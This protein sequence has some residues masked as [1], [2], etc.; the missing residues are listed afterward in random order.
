MNLQFDSKTRLSITD[1]LSHTLLEIIGK[2]NKRSIGLVIDSNIATHPDIKKMETALQAHHILLERIFQSSEPT[3][4]MVDS[5]AD[6][7]RSHTMDWIIGIGGGSTLD[8]AKAVSVM[9]GLPG[10]TED[11]HATGKALST[12]I[13]KIMVP[14]TAGTG[15]EV[16]PGAVLINPKK[17]LKR[18]LSGREVGSDYAVLYAP[19]TLA[20]PAAV[21]ASTGL[22]ALT[23]AIESYTARNA[24]PLT[25]MYSLRAF[26]LIFNNLNRVFNDPSNIQIRQELL[27]GSSLAGYAIY[28]SN[29]G[30]AHSIAYALGIYNKV[31]HGVGVGILIPHVVA[32]NI[33]RGCDLYADLLLALEPS[34]SGSRL[35]QS[36]RFLELLRTHSAY[37]ALHFDPAAYGLNKADLSFLAERGLD[38]QSALQNNPVPFSKEDAHD[39]LK[40]IVKVS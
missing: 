16:T 19:L 14:T 24:N 8:L 23:H 1:D 17:S 34:A 6:Y 12:S 2:E 36:R 15:G 40:A 31:P 18:A 3:T 33:E 39:V 26:T 21:T 22:D 9:I 13:K 27:L 11:Y 28:N 37:R 35:E 38:L 30:A 29:T 5:A 4:D 20:L 7:F 25:Q 10:K 32:R